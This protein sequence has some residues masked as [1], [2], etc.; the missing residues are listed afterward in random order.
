[1]SKLEFSMKLESSVEELMKVIMDFEK[2]PTFLPRQLKSVKIL[3]K[4]EIKIFY[5]FSP[6]C[7]QPLCLKN[8]HMDSFYIIHTQT[9][10]SSTKIAD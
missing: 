6:I 9:L 1:M 5:I 3:K 10:L 4:T 2:W 7:G 8:N